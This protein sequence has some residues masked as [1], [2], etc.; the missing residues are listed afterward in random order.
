MG[1]LSIILL[2]FIIKVNPYTLAIGGMLV[3]LLFTVEGIVGEAFYLSIVPVTIQG[4]FSGFQ[5]FV[6]GAAG[7]LAYLMSG[8]IVDLIKPFLESNPTLLGH[9]PGTSI[10]AAITVMFFGAGVLLAVLT[11]SFSRKK[12]IKE[13][14][15]IYAKEL[16]EEKAAS[17]ERKVVKGLEQKKEQEAEH[18]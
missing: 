14:D 7:P 6:L 13:L 1:C 15:V 12:S 5:S 3:V 11:L 18:V 10:T 8:G 16:A 2:L 4:R 17:K 9:L